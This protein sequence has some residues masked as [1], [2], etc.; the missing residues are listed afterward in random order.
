MKSNFIGAFILVVCLA[1]VDMGVQAATN[2]SQVMESFYVSGRGESLQKYKKE[3]ISTLRSDAAERSRALHQLQLE[4]RQTN[5]VQ[6]ANVSI[7]TPAFADLVDVLAAANRSEF[8]AAAKVIVSDIVA[9]DEAKTKILNRLHIDAISESKTKQVESAEIDVFRIAA[10]G[11]SRAVQ[12][13]ACRLLVG[14]VVGSNSIAGVD[15]AL[16]EQIILGK[17]R[18]DAFEQSGFAE[19]EPFAYVLASADNRYAEFYNQNVRVLFLKD[20]K[21]PPTFRRFYAERL[22]SLGLLNEAE[23]TKY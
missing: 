21:K 1:F 7:A 4:S 2:Y 6:V 9:K 8:T 14:Y 16:G 12:I 23:L 20:E 11:E 3:L 18:G 17:I 15:P 5:Q 10:N 19:N 22:H 13:H